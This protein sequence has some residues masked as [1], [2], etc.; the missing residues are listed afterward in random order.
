MVFPALS[1]GTLI[2]IAP[3][4]A[5][6]LKLNVG[7]SFSFLP[8]L[9]LRIEKYFLASGKRINYIFHEIITNICACV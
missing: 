2:S 8:D 6:F 1:I 9:N 4:S 3:S 7:I 5:A